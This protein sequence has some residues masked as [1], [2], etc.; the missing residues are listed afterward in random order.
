MVVG[1]GIK[2]GLNIL[3]DNPAQLGADMVAGAIAA[4][5]AYPCPCVIFDMGTANTAAVVAV[6]Y[7]H[8]DVYKRQR[9]ARAWEGA[10]TKPLIFNPFRL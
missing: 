7:T 5:D 9:L 3:I 10:E 8:L 6:S 1:P 4:I 2:T